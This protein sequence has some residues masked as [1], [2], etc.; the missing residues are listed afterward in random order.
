MCVE[1][2]VVLAV[3]PTGFGKSLILLAMFDFIPRGC[4]PGG[5]KQYSTVIVV[6]PLNAL[7]RNQLQVLGGLLNVFTLQRATLFRI[8]NVGTRKYLI[9]FEWSL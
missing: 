6:L 4:E 8:I 1:K 7:M 9:L 2:R 5:G 3:L